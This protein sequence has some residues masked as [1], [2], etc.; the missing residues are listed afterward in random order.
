MKINKNVFIA[1]IMLFPIIKPDENSLAFLIGADLAR[2]YMMFMTF[3]NYINIII[4]FCWFSYDVLRKKIRIS[5]LTKL[6]L[7]L[8]SILV[9][10]TLREF[11]YDASYII[12]LIGNLLLLFFLANIYTENKFL[13]FI[14][15]CCGYLT[16]LSIFNAITIYIYSP[17]TYRESYYLLGL[18]NMGFIIA[19]HAFFAGMICNIVEKNTIQL[20]LGILY[21]FIFGAYIYCKSG[22]AIMISCMLVLVLIFY[23]SNVMNIITYKKTI[24]IICI[25]FLTVTLMPNTYIWQTISNMMGKGSTFS[26][27][28]IIWLAMFSV[29]PKHLVI[30][31]GVEPEVTQHYIGLY[32]S[33]GWLN[34]IGHM[35]NIVLE[36]L[37]RGGIVGV[38][39]FLLI[40]LGCIE[41]MEK[42]KSEII[43]KVL[44]LQFLF[45]MVACMFEFRMDTYTFW[46]LPICLYE[47]EAL[48]NKF[49]I[50][51]L[52]D[53]R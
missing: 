16:M 35:H 41:K 26:G 53:Y 11:T 20:K 32:P 15:A 4:C 38:V 42:F 30:G 9:I 1:A 47:I 45:T 44:C 22:T 5:K 52:D 28:T 8:S 6:V 37:F 18:D 3:W 50:G 24:L 17:G 33:G 23:K 39:F 27:R 29:L 13:F 19:L 43:Y 34:G 51:K 7:L 31:F 14:K 25:I 46:I 12:K 48:N 10:A 49:K 36:F 21:V 2:L 40:W